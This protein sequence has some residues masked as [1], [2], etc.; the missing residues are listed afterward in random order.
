MIRRK[1]SLS[2]VW[3][4]TKPLW[5]SLFTITVLVIPM[6]L[7]HEFG[8][9][10]IC[11]GYGFDYVLSVSGIYL[12]THCSNEPFSL[13][14]YWSFGGILAMIACSMLLL[15]R[16]LRL[17]K[18]VAIGIVTVAFNHFLKMIFETFMH[19]GYLS[20]FNLNMFMDGSSIFLMFLLLWV[21]VFRP[22]PSKPI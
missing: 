14:L 15:S 2:E 21:F 17:N 5:I 10:L 7:I 1:R 20:N 11:V 9:I 6:V 3:I 22:K 16:K 18:G 13:E 19:S 12:N 4:E 8:H